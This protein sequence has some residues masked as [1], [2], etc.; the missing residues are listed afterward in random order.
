MR[1]HAVQIQRFEGATLHR[2]IIAVNSR[3][4][5]QAKQIHQV[6]SVFLIV[7]LATKS[8][9]EIP[10]ASHLIPSIFGKSRTSQSTGH[11]SGP[12]G[13]LVPTDRGLSC[14]TFAI[15]GSLRTVLRVAKI[16]CIAYNI[17]GGKTWG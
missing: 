10:L 4:Q 12:S 13:V 1:R 9:D 6:W 14:R 15:V 8:L 17:L 7:R 5:V 16:L 2:Y 3:T 11:P